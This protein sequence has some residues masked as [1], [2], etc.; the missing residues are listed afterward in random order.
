MSKEQTLEINST[1]TMV[2]LPQVVWQETIEKIDKLLHLVDS[3][4]GQSKRISAI[5]VRIPLIQFKE[6]I[7]LQRRY[8]LT[9][10]TVRRIA[11]DNLL[12]SYCD[13]G[14]QRYRWT[15]HEDII[16]YLTRIKNAGITQ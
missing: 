5:Q 4:G 6:D 1:V 12:R 9:Y 10:T 3:D 15:T 8:G 16:D 14:R 11:N 7:E 2:L 13:P